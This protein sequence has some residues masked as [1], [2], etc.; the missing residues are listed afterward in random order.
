MLP[1]SVFFHLLMM[2]L[3]SRLCGLLGRKC[4]FVACLLCG[5]KAVQGSRTLKGRPLDFMG[6]RAYTRHFVLSPSLH[7]FWRKSKSAWRRISSCWWHQ[8]IFC[9][10]NQPDL[11][12]YDRLFIPAFFCF[13]SYYIYFSFNNTFFLFSFLLCLLSLVLLYGFLF[14]FFYFLKWNIA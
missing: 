2:E 10:L 4:L 14:F 13:S 3:H 7:I 11:A 8:T 9:C 1:L 6:H 5:D 12:P